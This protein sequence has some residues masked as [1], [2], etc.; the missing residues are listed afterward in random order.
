MDAGSL[1]DMFDLKARVAVVT[2]GNGGIGLGIARGLAQH[3][4]K[5][6]I[7]ARDAE[8][9]GQAVDQLKRLGFDASGLE[10]D[11][12]S[13]PSIAGMISKAIGVHGGIDILVNNAGI[14]RVN[15]ADRF[16]ADDWRKII[17][18]NLTGAYL[19]CKEVYPH[20]SANRGGK[21]I[22][23]ASMTATFGS[24]RSLPYGASKS[25]LVQLTKSLA[26]AWADENIQVNAISPG[27]VE[28]EMT[29]GLR[30]SEDPEIQEIHRGI[31]ER[32]PAGRWARPED[33]A[34]AA[35]FLASAASN[36]VT[37]AV[38]TVDGGY[39]IA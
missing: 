23:I 29:E 2:G 27:W 12:Q 10:F 33:M 36:Y 26:I 34:G 35:V 17:D 37:G 3:G 7:A 24:K 18:T 16:T 20:M 9:T 11:V 38:L 6:I 39:S 14:N 31:T 25:G 19:L 30:E 8:K 4:A 21:I 1:K 15:F 32:I 22:N 5:V 13:E 28:T